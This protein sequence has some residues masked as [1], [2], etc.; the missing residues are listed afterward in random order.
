MP[1]LLL[2][3]LAAAL[4]FGQDAERRFLP[5]ARDKVAKQTAAAILKAACEGDVE[6]DSCSK[7]PGTD[8][9]G[10]DQGP[11]A[12][13]PLV[14]GHFSAAGSEEAFAGVGGCYYPGHASPIALFL[15]KRDGTWATLDTI[16]AF[17]PGNCARRQFRS[18]REFLICEFYDYSQ[19]G[20]RS[21]RLSMV[22]VE[23]DGS[24]F[25]D[26]FIAADTTRVCQEGNAQQAEVK[27]VEF[28]DLNGD[29]LEDISI[30]ATLGSFPMTGRRKEQCE[31]AEED[32]I[33]SDGKPSKPFPRPSTART[34]KIDLL[35]DGASYTP[36]PASRAA[37]A[38]FQSDR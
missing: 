8:Q 20:E 27:K 4:A 7:C 9:G 31:A 11:W 24:K 16:L 29:G 15:G 5:P 37:A 35:F 19:G 1:L 12:I 25:H 30:T 6:G 32:R 33:Q 21:Y 34:Y 13:S 36:T 28:R 18:G 23:N 22:T 3:L 17:D 26:L 2:L 38:L 14:V 10:T